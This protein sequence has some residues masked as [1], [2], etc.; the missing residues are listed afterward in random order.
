MILI[1]L[2]AAVE[3]AEEACTAG[4]GQ[5]D[6]SDS[7]AVLSSASASGGCAG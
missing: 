1:I 6:A 3:L 7:P 4:Q 2:Y 5:V